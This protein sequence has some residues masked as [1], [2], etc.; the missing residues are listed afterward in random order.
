MSG[1]AKMRRSGTI[2]KA[3]PKKKV[4]PKV[5][6]KAGRMLMYSFS[7]TCRDFTVLILI[8][9]VLLKLAPVGCTGVLKCDMK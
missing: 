9:F 2:F 6:I 5:L 8:P 4:P 7:E 3:A 1:E